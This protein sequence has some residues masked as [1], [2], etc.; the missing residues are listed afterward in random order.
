MDILESV[1]KRMSIRAFKPD[2]VHKEVLQEIMERAL[3]A[4]S[5]G[6]TQ[7]WDFY[8][9]AGN[10]LAEI[11]KEFMEKQIGMLRPTSAIQPGRQPVKW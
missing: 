7:P 4:P 5:W 1:A 9:A 8:M 6:N 3:L 10:K 11:Q 2:P